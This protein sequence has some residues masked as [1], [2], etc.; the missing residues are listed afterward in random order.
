MVN[1][2]TRRFGHRTF[3]HHSEIW[4]SLWSCKIEPSRNIFFF[5]FLHSFLPV[6]LW[7]SILFVFVDLKTKPKSKRISISLK[8]SL[9]TLLFFDLPA[10]I[11]WFF[12]SVPF[13]FSSWFSCS[14][15]FEYLNIH[16]EETIEEDEHWSHRS[17]FSLWWCSVYVQL[18][19][20]YLSGMLSLV[21][22]Y[23]FILTPLEENSSPFSN[24]TRF[25]SIT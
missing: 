15:S 2:L 17:L 9:W 22:C 8:L 10:T 13:F 11:N 4:S 23:S 21:H 12:F 3:F 5:W 25:S 16:R 24:N 1:L 19:S 7:S 6:S 20:S 18:V 14:D